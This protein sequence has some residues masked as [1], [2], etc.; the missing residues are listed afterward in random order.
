LRPETVV[1]AKRNR[2]NT[3]IAARMDLL[4]LSVLE[5]LMVI[6]VKNFICCPFSR[7]QRRNEEVKLIASD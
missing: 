4:E 1:D 3:R 7:K 2:A 5:L 6:A